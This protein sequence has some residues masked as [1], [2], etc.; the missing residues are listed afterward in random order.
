MPDIIKTEAIVLR[1]NKLLQ[2]DLHITLFTE[3]IGKISAFA[4]G[5]KNITSRRAPHIQTG[6]LV[7]I[8]LNKSKNT[9]Y[10]QQSQLRSGFSQIKDSSEKIDA[11]YIMFFLL[12]RLLPEDQKEL[13][14][15]NKTKIFLIT[16]SKSREYSNIDLSEAIF[17]LLSTLGYVH[18]KKSL[19]ELLHIVEDIIHE[20]I[21][22]NTINL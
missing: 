10:L 9:Y 4:K 22:K 1:K 5:I 18:E 13:E 8:V 2:K 14:V 17:T 15:Y 16:V 11:M 12:D 20:K 6:N 21:P 3:E 7:N 19:N